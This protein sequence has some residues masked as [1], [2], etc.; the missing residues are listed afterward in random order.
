MFKDTELYKH[1]VKELDLLFELE[2]Q[3]NMDKPIG[4]LENECNSFGGMTAQEFMNEQILNVLAS[5]DST[6]LTGFTMKYL[7]DTVYTLCRY[8]NLTPLT[9]A[10][11]EFEE[12]AEDENGCK[13]YQNKRNFSVF[14][15]DSKG[16]YHIDGKDE[17]DRACGKCP[18]EEALKCED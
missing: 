8:W 7:L 1:A 16:V 9:L 2:R 10:D 11:D 17:L 18:E 4:E 12:V 3:E 13:L 5:I 14:K 6:Q 15:S